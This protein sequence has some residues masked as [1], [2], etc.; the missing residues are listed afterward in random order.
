MIVAEKKDYPICSFHEMK[1]EK[2]FRQF[3]SL[4]LKQNVNSNVHKT[5]NYL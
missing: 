5:V 3:E 1:M 2:P 4:L